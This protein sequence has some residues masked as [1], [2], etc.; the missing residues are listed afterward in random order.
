MLERAQEVE[1]GNE[2]TQDEQ[3]NKNGCFSLFYFLFAM[4][5]LGWGFWMMVSFS[6]V[7]PGQKARLMR[8]V[9]RPKTRQSARM[10]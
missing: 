4:I 3:G 5:F 2:A 8:M 7:H 10:K 9:G 6:Y 1:W